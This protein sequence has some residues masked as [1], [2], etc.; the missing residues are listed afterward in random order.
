MLN[1]HRQDGPWFLV[2]LLHKIEAFDNQDRPFQIYEETHLAYEAYSPLLEM[3]YF[4]VMKTV[5]DHFHE[6]NN[7]L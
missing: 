3:E 4:I 1:F 2:V 6:D 5:W 7:L